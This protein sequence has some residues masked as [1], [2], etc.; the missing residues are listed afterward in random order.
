M[1]LGAAGNELELGIS[2]RVL[3]PLDGLA[4]GLKAVAH[5]LEQFADLR[6]ADLELL[7][8]ELSCQRPRAL[9]RPTQW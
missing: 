3:L 6:A 7:Q 4:V 9:D 2:V 5:V 8:P 1:L